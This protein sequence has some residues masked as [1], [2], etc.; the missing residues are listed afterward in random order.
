MKEQAAKRKRG[1]NWRL[2]PGRLHVWIVEAIMI[3]SL[4]IGGA[5]FLKYEFEKAFGPAH[6]AVDVPK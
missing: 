5:G 2:K 6:P 4:V 3:L 1:W